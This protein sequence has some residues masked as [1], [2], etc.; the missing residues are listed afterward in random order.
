MTE[1]F[2]DNLRDS[3]NGRGVFGTQS[4]ILNGRLV[5]VFKSSQHGTFYAV[6]REFYAVCGLKNQLIILDPALFFFRWK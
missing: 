3:K 6:L 5:S 2:A 1:S 4:N